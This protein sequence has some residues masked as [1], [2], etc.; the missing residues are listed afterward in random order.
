MRNKLLTLILAVALCFSM[1]FVLAC[2]DNTPK[3][4]GPTVVSV[5]VGEKTDLFDVAEGVAVADVSVTIYDTAVATASGKEVTG[6]KAGVTGAEISYDDT[7]YNVVIS[8]EDPDA[9]T[10]AIAAA[11]TELEQKITES[12]SSAKTEL[13]TNIDSLKTALETAI[14]DLGMEDIDGLVGQLDEIAADIAEKADAAE[15]K[16]SIAALEKAV[17]EAKTA[18]QTAIDNLDKELT[19]E[20]EAQI[21]TVN[22]TIDGVKNSVTALDEKMTQAQ[23]DIDA[24]EKAVADLEAQ[25]DKDSEGNSLYAKK[26]NAK[27]ELMA[28][29]LEKGH[30]SVDFS[31]IDAATTQEE[32]DS[33]VAAIRAEYLEGEEVFDLNAY[34]ANAAAEIIVVYEN[35]IAPELVKL[36]DLANIAAVKEAT[37]RER[38]IA[39]V[40]IILA[41]TKADVD[42][43]L[44][45]YTENCEKIIEDYVAMEDFVDALDAFYA[46]RETAGI[47]S[48]DKDAI[49]AL[50]KQY[51]ELSDEAK[52]LLKSAT[53]KIM[54]EDGEVTVP[55]LNQTVEET[56]TPGAYD[57]I[58]VI[59]TL[60]GKIEAVYVAGDG[61]PAEGETPAVPATPLEVGGTMVNEELVV[62][63]QFLEERKEALT[64]V[65]NGYEALKAYQFYLKGEMDVLED[66]AKAGAK[67]QDVV[68]LLHAEEYADEF[69]AAFKAAVIPEGATEITYN[70]YITNLY[71]TKIQ[72]DSSRA[73]KQ[74]QVKSAQTVAFWAFY[75]GVVGKIDGATADQKIG[76]IAAVPATPSS[77]TEKAEYDVL[78]AAYVTTAE[79]ALASA[80]NV[81]TYGTKTTDSYTKGEDQVY[82]DRVAAVVGAEGA[83]SVKEAYN[84]INK[85]VVAAGYFA[86]TVEENYNNII[87]NYETAYADA[88]AFIKQMIEETAFGG[89]AGDFKTDPTRMAFSTKLTTAYAALEGFAPYYVIDLPMDVYTV[90]TTIA[91]QNITEVYATVETAVN[92]WTATE[93]AKTP[94]DKVYNETYTAEAANTLIATYIATAKKAYEVVSEVVPYATSEDV[95]AKTRTQAMAAHAAYVELVTDEVATDYAAANNANAVTVNTH[96]N[97]DYAAAEKYLNAVIAHSFD[98]YTTTVETGEGEE[99]TTETKPVYETFAAGYAAEKAALSEFAQKYIAAGIQNLVDVYGDY[100]A[101]VVADT[102]LA[103]LAAVKEEYAAYT[104]TVFG[105][106]DLEADKLTEILTQEVVDKLLTDY[107]TSVEN[108]QKFAANLF[109]GAKTFEKA[110]TLK[111]DL[112]A[113]YEAVG[114]QTITDEYLA[115]VYVNVYADYQKLYGAI[116]VVDGKVTVPAINDY[117]SSMEDWMQPYVGTGVELAKTLANFVAENA[118]GETC[119]SAYE[120]LVKDAPLAYYYLSDELQTS[121]REIERK[122]LINDAVSNI[123]IQLTTYTALTEENKTDENVAKIAAAINSWF[124]VFDEYLPADASDLTE[125]NAYIQAINDAAGVRG[126]TEAVVVGETYTVAYEA[127]RAIVTIPDLIAEDIVE[128]IDAFYKANNAFL[129]TPNSGDN[130]AIDHAADLETLFTN[131]GKTGLKDINDAITELVAQLAHYNVLKAIGD[132]TYGEVQLDAAVKAVADE[133]V[134]ST[135][136]KTAMIEEINAI[137]TDYTVET[138]KAADDYE[139]GYNAKLAAFKEACEALG[140]DYNYIWS[141]DADIT[142]NMNEVVALCTDLDSLVSGIT[143]MNTIYFTVVPEVVAGMPAKTE[144]EKQA[145]RDKLIAENKYTNEEINNIVLRIA[146]TD[147]EILAAMEANVL[148][149]ETKHAYE[150]ANNAPVYAKLQAVRDDIAQKELEKEELAI[151]EEWL[152]EVNNFSAATPASDVAAAVAEV[153]TT[154]FNSDTI[155]TDVAREAVKEKA[156]ELQAIVANDSK[157]LYDLKTAYDAA[158]AASEAAPEDTDLQAALEAAE[159]AYNEAVENFGYVFTDESG[160]KTLVISV[161]SWGGNAYPFFFELQSTLG[162]KTLVVSNIEA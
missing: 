86:E 150:I 39:F 65:S 120:A 11:K 69:I 154:F 137:V 19:E 47:V 102:D 161:A 134:T 3:V 146:M 49:A 89:A 2:K 10:N 106:Y 122:K 16:A 4:T 25:L 76:D 100:V 7:T 142:K 18:L 32:L 128:K 88:A 61:K 55:V 51:N 77:E 126:F 130:D 133:L 156:L 46:E 6:V 17:T 24:L 82:V 26:V 38:E 8:V 31:T 116:A 14:A 107:V 114:A 5:N 80:K 74:V 95:V 151:A 160:N 99:V 149:L 141:N 81:Y 27:V 22:A 92:N 70:A 132:Y 108:T 115:E 113:V 153:Y 37:T 15:V 41:N 145:I 64:E 135:A 148:A 53:V 129:N 96:Y 158:K 112:A 71:D 62:I 52:E 147:E 60:I 28:E 79:T 9:I 59:D 12:V 40:Q 68:D 136:R 33:A 1:S 30:H 54:M 131:E 23:A 21:K 94:N 144:E 57:M 43:I 42:E 139:T 75:N 50:D 104:D 84:T 73:W 36:S 123:A 45:N 140:T 138:F 162:A 117:A 152:A 34:K 111:A 44:K 125:R 93:G 155:T 87:A 83:P 66:K 124:K 118:S 103:S 13:Q 91:G 110:G 109:A 20:I 85:N 63:D 97:V 98:A 157:E 105:V 67:A 58:H 127:A 90:Y 56:T 143:S 48:A 101:K 29:L 72:N 35:T 119:V 159:T 78:Y 121:Y